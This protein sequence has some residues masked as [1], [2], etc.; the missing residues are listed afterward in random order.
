MLV[1][2]FRE[3]AVRCG[4]AAARREVAASPVAPRDDISG[5]RGI[6]ANAGRGDVVLTASD[7]AAER[8]E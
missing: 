4:F 8:S 3:F 1:R 7:P 2:D 5:G 6:A